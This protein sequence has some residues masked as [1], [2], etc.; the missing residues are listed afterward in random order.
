MDIINYA[1][2]ANLQSDSHLVLDLGEECSVVSKLILGI[3]IV[4]LQLNSLIYL[5][6][7]Q[8]K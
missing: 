2:A 7:L 3:A 1:L 5:A 4:K 8:E 6:L